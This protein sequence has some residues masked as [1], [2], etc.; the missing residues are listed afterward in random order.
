MEH[1]RTEIDIAAS[2]AAV[3]HVLTDFPAYPAWNPF[4][5]SIRGSQA[6]GSP[7]HVTVQPEGGKPMSFKPRLLIFEP[8]KEL[9]WKGR[10]LAPGIFD[11]EHYFA[12]SEP[13]PGTV[14]FVHG[15]V[16]RGLLVPLVFRGA[17]RAG[18]ER[19]FAAMNR[20]LQARAEAQA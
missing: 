18:T 1:I 20:A 17:M 16:F 5:R 8:G 19:G 6:P 13:S 4:V 15:E 2:P 14:H 11:G 10:L 7:L 3:W 9:R 12:L